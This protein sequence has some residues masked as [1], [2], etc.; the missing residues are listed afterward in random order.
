M[1]QSQLTKEERDRLFLKHVYDR[2]LSTDYQPG[3][4]PIGDNRWL[5]PDD[6]DG[7][8]VKMAL[9][10]ALSLKKSSGNEQA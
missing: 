7:I 10:Q 9:D 8:Y 2:Q 6:V 4:V 3:K 1:S 5:Y